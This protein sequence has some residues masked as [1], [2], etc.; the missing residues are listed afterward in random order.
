M[1]SRHRKQ[2]WEN[3]THDRLS[4]LLISLAGWWWFLRSTTTTLLSS[5]RSLPFLRNVLNL[6]VDEIIMIL[7]ACESM[8]N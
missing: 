8:V 5:Q 3:G 7:G 4:A 2:E 6:A 1:A